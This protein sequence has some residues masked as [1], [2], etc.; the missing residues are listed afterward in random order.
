MTLEEL[1]NK[2]L[3]NQKRIAVPCP[4]TW[5]ERITASCYSQLHFIMNDVWKEFKQRKQTDDT[6]VQTLQTQEHQNISP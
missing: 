5:L 4:M 2:A 3:A 1:A 6:T